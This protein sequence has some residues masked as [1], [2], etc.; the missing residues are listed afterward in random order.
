MGDDSQLDLPP[1]TD[2]IRYDSYLILSKP[3][4]LLSYAPHMHTRAKAECLE[5]IYP[6]KSEQRDGSK[7]ET[8]NC[9]NHFDFNWMMVYEYATDVQPLLP[10][11]TVLHL[12]SWYNNTA[13]NRLNN[14]P[15]NWIGY[16]QRSID[17]MAMA[18]MTYVNLTDDEFQQAVAERKAKTKPIENLSSK[19]TQ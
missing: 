18:W 11:G 4:R 3:T 17:D 5:A 6:Q 12:I 2:N 15:N 9:I 1:N 14:D 13:S 8:L 10:P 7:V 19:V 16:G